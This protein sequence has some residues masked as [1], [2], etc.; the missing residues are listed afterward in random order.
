MAARVYSATG[1]ALAAAAELTCRRRSQHASV[2]CSFTVPARA[3]RR[4]GAAPP[5]ASRRRAPGQPH[6]VN[7]TSARAAAPRRESIAED[8]KRLALGNVGDRLQAREV[9]GA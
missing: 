3:R 8:G 7:N 1:I 9:L 5:P 2:M 6:A 4:A